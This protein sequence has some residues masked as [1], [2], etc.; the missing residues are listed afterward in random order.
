MTVYMVVVQH[1][2]DEV[3]GGANTFQVREFVVAEVK[4][5]DR[6]G[7]FLHVGG[8][9]RQASVRQREVA[10]WCR[11]IHRNITTLNTQSYKLIGRKYL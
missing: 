8:E 7:M 9:L 11:F 4:L 5:L 2:G 3:P 1:Q 10:L 6:C